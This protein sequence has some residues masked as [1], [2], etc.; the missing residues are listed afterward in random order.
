MSLQNHIE[1]LRG[2]PEHVRRRVAFF[3]AF[4]I[5]A[6]IFVFWLA[7]I[8]NVGIGKSAVAEAVDKAGTP[9]QSLIAGVGSV[10]GELKDMIFGPKKVNYSSVTISPGKR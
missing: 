3:Y 1:S 10:A 2:K 5:T 9:S 7:S 4:G 8:T 6:V